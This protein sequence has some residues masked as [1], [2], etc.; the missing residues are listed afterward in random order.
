MRAELLADLKERGYALFHND[1]HDNTDS[2]DDDD[3][4]VTDEDTSEVDLAKGYEYL[5][6]MKIWSLT[7]ER[8]EEL[9]MQ[10]AEKVNEFETLQTT[11]PE[12]IWL[13]DLDAIEVL[14]DERDEALGINSKN[15]IQTKSKSSLSKKVERKTK[16][17][18]DEVSVIDD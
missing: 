8:A 1:T 5:L 13:A 11:P 10:R 4:A 16:E 9:R 12:R 3:D 17:K 18:V 14:L 7:F 6:G 2:C 15:H